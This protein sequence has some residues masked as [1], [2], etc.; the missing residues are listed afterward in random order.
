MPENNRE[1]EIRSDEV[2]EI[3]SHV[4][5]WIIRWGISLFFALICL[6]IF[7]TYFIKYPDVVEGSVILTTLNPPIKLVTKNAGEINQIYF[8]D[9][10]SIKK[11]DIIVTLNNS[12]SKEAKVYLEK[13][14][15]EI[16]EELQKRTLMSYDMDNS[17][18][19]FGN[20][21]VDYSNLVSGVVD[22]QYL[23]NENN[24]AFKIVNL[25]KQIHNH[26]M[27]RSVTEKQFKSSTKQLEQAKEKYISDQLLYE[28]GVFS[29]MQ[30]YEEEKQFNIAKNA[31]NN[32]EKTTIQ[33][34][35][36]LTDL[37]KQLNDL[38]F[39]FEKEKAELL[40]RIEMSLANIENAIANWELGFQIKSPIDG[41]LTY[42]QNLNQNEFV[43]SGKELFAVVPDN[44][45]YIGQIKIP[46]T[47]YGKIEIGQKVRMKFDNYPY[48]EYGQ[49]NGVVSDI[50]LIA[51][52]ATYLIKVQL[53][54]G[55]NSS[56][57]KELTYTPEMS[58]TAEIITKDLRLMERIF[59]KF[60]TILDK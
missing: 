53:T 18:F 33:H 21:Q 12:L 17:S 25:K 37:E 28:K 22:Y 56:Y 26:Q 2:Q 8:E 52:E 31:V 3:M 30:F 51:N 55:M 16:R 36:T 46:Q 20:A 19:V 5:N 49:L 40:Q 27:L 47:G 42:L 24:T 45:E 35:I 48:Q 11:G 44:Q 58:G 6:F 10:S 50:S 57:D 29:K 13:I 54:G 39:N 23:V 43:T 1:I 4:P 38:E 9:N 34:S 60:R 59:N 15:R 14:N 7:I 32:L 41:K